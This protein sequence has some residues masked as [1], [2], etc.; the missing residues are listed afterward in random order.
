VIMKV[1]RVGVLCHTPTFE[2][3]RDCFPP[4]V[5]GIISGSGRETMPCIMQTGK[6]D[7][8]A[9]IGTSQAAD[10]LQKAHPKPHRL[11]VCLGLEAKN[12]AIVLADSDIDASVKEIVLG[13]LS[14]NGQRCTALKIVFVHKQIR[15]AF[16]P[17]LCDAIDKL[18]MGL[19]WEEGVNITP[20]PEE[21]KPN[22]LKSLIEDALAKGAKIAN[23]R[24]GNSD[25]SFVA[26]TVLFPVHKDMRVYHEEQF[27]PLVPVCEFDSLEEVYNY[28]D[29]SDYGQQASIF[30]KDAKSAAALIDVLANQVCRVNINSQCQRGPD[31]LPF[32]GRKDSAYGTLS[33]SDALRVFSV[34]VLTAGKEDKSTT[35]IANKIVDDRL[36][37]FLRMDYIF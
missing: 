27:G 19:P 1:P 30:T 3:F 21:G 10:E 14:F 11:R 8:F 34:R 25:R 9:F 36:S 31:S 28:L 18:K 15:E 33:V 6:I 5:V 7:S 23:A 35:E 20:L 17:K 4:G 29:S 12:P 24:G 37:T 2:L 13:A 26:P 32:S 22:Y 16:L